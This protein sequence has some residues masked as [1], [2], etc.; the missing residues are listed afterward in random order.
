MH[1]EK[2][3]MKWA[4]ELIATWSI[5]LFWWMAY[6]LYKVSQ[7][8]QFKWGMFFINWFLAFWLATI[9]GDFLPLTMSY[10]DWLIGLATFSTHPILK[11][12][13]KHFGKF[14][15]KRIVWQIDEK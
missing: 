13:E 8:E 14:I 7:W 11:L 1:T 3:L 4:M 12:V 5:G 15:F 10:R 2:D 6:Y 9:V